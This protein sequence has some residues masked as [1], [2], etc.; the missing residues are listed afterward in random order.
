LKAEILLQLGRL[1]EA[2]ATIEQAWASDGYLNPTHYAWYFV[3]LGEEHR[4]RTI[5]AKANL[6]EETAFDYART[7][8]ALGELEKGFKALRFSAANMDSRLISSLMVSEEWDPFRQDPRFAEI[9]ASIESRI[10]HTERYLEESGK[11]VSA[12]P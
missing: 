8:L 5:L 12:S 2:E 10:T 4:A 9:I 11:A 7:Y 1:V 3:K 6:T